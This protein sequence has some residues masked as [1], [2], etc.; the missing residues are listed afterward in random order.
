[1]HVK[2]HSCRQL[3]WQFWYQWRILLHNFS[4]LWHKLKETSPFS[5][6]I[7]NIQ[8]LNM[9]GFLW[10]NPQHSCHYAALRYSTNLHPSD[11]A[12]RQIIN[13]EQIPNLRLMKVMWLWTNFQL[14]LALDYS[15]VI[16][17]FNFLDGASKLNSQLSFYLHL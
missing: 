8:P 16:S 3:D 4:K 17:F 12:Y 2:V 6:F 13:I 14:Q 9:W 5:L 1:M 7:Y 10:C 11:K 15:L